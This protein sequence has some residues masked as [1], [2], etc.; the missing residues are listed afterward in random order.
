MPSSFLVSRFVS[1]HGTLAALTLLGLA[2]LPKAAQAQTLIYDNGSFVTSNAR[3]IS[4]FAVADDFTFSGTQT[5]D[6]GRIWLLSTASSSLG[7][8]SGTLSWLIYDDNAGK[9]GSVLFSGTNSG[10]AITRTDTGANAFGGRIFQLDFP[11]ASTTLGAG[12]Y[13]F[14]AKEGALGD[15]GDGTTVFW[16]DS[17]SVTGFSSQQDTDELNPTSWGSIGRDRAFQLLTSSSSA[18]EP[19]T[20][21]LVALGA[22]GGIVARRRR[23]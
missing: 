20:L 13:W 15:L 23:K 9:P 14:R 11:I 22:V 8:F 12:T 18:P 19:G 16:M 6:Q 2:A 5:F 21:A 3:G 7:S 10:A 4:D 17:P 1:T